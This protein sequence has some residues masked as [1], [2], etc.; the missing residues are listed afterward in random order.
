MARDSKVALGFVLLALISLSALTPA[1]QSQRR[2]N[3]VQ[4]SPTPTSDYEVLKTNASLVQVDAV[5]TDKQGRQVADL[6]AN[7][8]EIVEGGR[9]ITPEYF[10]YTPRNF[11]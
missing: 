2:D 10:S 1:Q 4:P 7:D 6:T 11:R 3:R 5:V 9:T 8:F